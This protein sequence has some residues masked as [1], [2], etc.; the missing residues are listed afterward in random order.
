MFTM[1]LV[2]FSIVTTVC[3]LNVYHR[4]PSTHHMPTWVKQL[5]LASLPT[6]LLMRRP[7]SVS[8]RSKPQQRSAKK[9]VS[10]TGKEKKQYSNSRRSDIPTDPNSFYV[11]E[12]IA[13]KC[14]WKVGDNQ[15]SQWDADV[16]EAV[17]GVRYIA[18][19]MKTEDD[20]EK[21]RS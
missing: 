10:R 14:C 13:P 17:D 9:N 4:S 19:H 12:D 16:E 5:F 15:G 2:T 3:V 6:C 18:G 8:V 1:V 7:G 11:D 21:V 20:N